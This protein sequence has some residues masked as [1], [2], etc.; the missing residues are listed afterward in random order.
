MAGMYVFCKPPPPLAIYC[1]ERSTCV[2]LSSDVDDN[3]YIKW[4]PNPKGCGNAVCGS[5]VFA[6]ANRPGLPGGLDGCFAYYLCVS[7]LRVSQSGCC[8]LA[9]ARLTPPTRNPLSFLI[10][11]SVPPP[12]LVCVDLLQDRVLPAV[13]CWRD[14]QLRH[15]VLLRLSAR[16]PHAL[17]RRSWC[18]HCARARVCLCVCARVGVC[19]CVCV[20]VCVRGFVCVCMVAYGGRFAGV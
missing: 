18:V 3:D 2:C 12:L 15:D 9:R 6:R 10:C 5:V 16:G 11:F 13:G 1:A 19:V 7:L 4:C 17:H 8:T 14:L 20:C